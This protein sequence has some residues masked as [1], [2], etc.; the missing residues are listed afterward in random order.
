MKFLL[1]ATIT[2]SIN[3]Y[4]FKCD[5]VLEG[6]ELWELDDKVESFKKSF[7][8]TIPFPKNMM[9]AVGHETTEDCT[10]AE[11]EVYN[12][13]PTG[14]SFKVISTRD[15]FCDGGN[16]FGYITNSKDEVLASVNDSFIS[17]L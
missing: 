17:C 6:I 9:T 12:F 14:E 4:A 2:L 16:S 1:L 8:K 13:L 10:V 5:D 11:L 7:S 3:S 15:D